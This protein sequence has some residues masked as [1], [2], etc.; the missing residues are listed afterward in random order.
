M[1]TQTVSHGNI[2]VEIYVDDTPEN[3]R[4]D[5]N[6]TQFVMFHRRYR[7]P[8][9]TGI[10]NYLDFFD[11]WGKMQLDLQSKFK[12]VTSVYMLDHSGLYFSLSDFRDRWD[13]GQV[14][15]IV[16][17]DGTYEEFQKRAQIELMEYGY[18]A[19]GECYGFTVN[20][21]EEE[22]TESSWNYYGPDHRES[23]LID[24]LESVLKHSF[25]Q[26]PTDIQ[27]IVKQLY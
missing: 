16:S 26:N 15:F 21:T 1:K 7:L 14:G 8:N 17:N 24:S 27:F 3:P 18:Y 9:E 20:E 22:D 12:Y 11:T 5:C 25:N 23:G 13:S 4:M 19:N 10:P 2:T 6:Q